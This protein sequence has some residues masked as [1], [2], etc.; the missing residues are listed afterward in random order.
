MNRKQK[1][2]Y[3]V[4]QIFVALTSIFNLNS[5]THIVHP[6]KECQVYWSERVFWKIN[7]FNELCFNIFQGIW[8]KE[9]I[10]K[11][12]IFWIPATPSTFWAHSFFIVPDIPLPKICRPLSDRSSASPYTGHPAWSS[13]IWLLIPIEMLLLSHWDR[14]LSMVQ[15]IGICCFS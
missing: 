14:D 13:A 5:W 6:G 1:Q 7:Y 2:I 8:K 4:I 11:I 12:G 3:L 10:E 15:C 9:G